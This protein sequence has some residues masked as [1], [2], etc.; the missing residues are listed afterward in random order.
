MGAKIIKDNDQTHR[1]LE[2]T[3]DLAGMHVAI[4]VIG[5][6]A[7]WKPY[8]ERNGE[9]SNVTLADVA[10][11]NEF[12]TRRIPARSFM[13]STFDENL[14]A[15]SRW[16]ERLLPTLGIT[17]SAQG[18]AEMIGIKM[19]ADVTQKIVDLKD[20]PNAPATIAR[21]KST[22]PLIHFG[23]LRQSIA[24]EVRKK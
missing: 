16:I 7:S 2:A 5:G 21:K 1:I 23:H 12:G 24:Y 6:K 4:G 20:P 13:R 10:S 3:Q 9:P 11:F 18:V 19:Q 15:Y 8:K 14:D 22:N 17:R